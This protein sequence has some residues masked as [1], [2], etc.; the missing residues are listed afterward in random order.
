[1]RLVIALVVWIA[2]IAGAAELSTVVAHSVHNQVAAASFDASTV[3]STD[4]RSLFRTTNFEKALAVVRKHFGPGS[5]LERLV[6]YPGYLDA[7]VAVSSGEVNVYVNA[8]GTYDPTS[9]SATPSQNDPLIKLSRIKANVPAALG[10][11]IATSGHVPRAALNYMIAENDSISH[12]LHW[13]V[14]IKKGYS[15]EY[16][17]APGTTGRLLVLKTNSKIGLEPVGR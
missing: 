8:A 3:T 6:V 14:Y 1:M 5:Q 17:Q 12:R 4:A 9:T 16:F 7:T 15:A 11:R 10:S 2:A 13:L